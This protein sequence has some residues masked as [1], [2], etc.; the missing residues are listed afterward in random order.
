MLKN[1]GDDSLLKDGLTGGHFDDGR[2]GVESW[3]LVEINLMELL[4]KVQSTVW[5]E[6]VLEIIHEY[7][8]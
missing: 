4:K 1:H 7:Q 3:T 8:N 5:S 6:Q 2:G